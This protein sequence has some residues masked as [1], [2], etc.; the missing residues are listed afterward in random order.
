[1]G[2]RRGQDPTGRGHRKWDSWVVAR[3]RSPGR[4][5][6]VT[7]SAFQ[8]LG[9]TL[10]PGG[11]CCQCCRGGEWLGS[12]HVAE[13]RG[14]GAGGAGEPGGAG[15]A[16]MRMGQAQRMLEEGHQ[17]TGIELGGRRTVFLAESENAGEFCISNV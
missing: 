15:W 4:G 6:G 12:E 17:L 16:A 7:V 5:Q 11:G 1:M 13:G 14:S 2:W 3:G 8:G 10:E 9:G